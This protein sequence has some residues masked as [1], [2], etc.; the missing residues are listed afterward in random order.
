MLEG[1]VLVWL[2]NI[3]VVK[4]GLGG[5]SHKN[6]K[7]KKEKKYKKNKNEKPNGLYEQSRR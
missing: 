1:N 7:R 5:R 6:E 2:V 4:V 3:P